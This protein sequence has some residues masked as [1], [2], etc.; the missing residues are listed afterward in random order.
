MPPPIKQTGES[1]KTTYRELFMIKLLHARYENSFE[2]FLQQAI[3]IM[4]DQRTRQLFIDRRISYR[5]YANTLTCFMECSLY[6]PPAPEPK[7][8]FIPLDGDLHIRFL[9]TGSDDFVRATYIVAAGSRHVYDFTNKISNTG[10]GVVFLTSPV[11]NHSLAGDYEIGTLVQSGGNLFTCIKT[12]LAAD[13][14]SISDTT[15]WHQ[16]DPVAQVVNNAD[17]KDTATVKPDASCLAVIDMFRNGT[18]DSSYK[19]F[20]TGDQ[21]FKPAPVFTIQF[22]SRF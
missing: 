6:N 13:S 2:N 16:L 15:F 3:A 10:G 18:V 5:F 1:V 7:V 20:D 12:A 17:L 8:P 19:I 4:P 22:K 14:I 21:L 11:E 9:L